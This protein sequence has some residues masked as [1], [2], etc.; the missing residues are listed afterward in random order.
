MIVYLS[1][2]GS[3]RRLRPKRLSQFQPRTRDDPLSGVL[4]DGRLDDILD[5][6]VLRD[7]RAVVAGPG[8]VN[9]EVTVLCAHQTLGAIEAGVDEEITCCGGEEGDGEGEDV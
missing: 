1:K 2:D 6:S 3:G 8:E 4:S 9:D 7:A 5:F